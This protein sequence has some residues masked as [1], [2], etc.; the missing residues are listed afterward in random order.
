MP[1][2]CWLLHIL[3]TAL[4]DKQ[5]GAASKRRQPLPTTLP[6]TLTPSA[7]VACVCPQRIDQRQDYASFGTTIS[8]ECMY[9][10]ATWYPLVCPCVQ[11]S[12]TRRPG[13][14]RSHARRPGVAVPARLLRLAPAA[15]A[16]TARKELCCSAMPLR[17][18]SHRCTKAPWERGCQQTRMV[19]TGIVPA[20]HASCCKSNQVESSQCILLQVIL[21]V[22]RYQLGTVERRLPRRRSLAAY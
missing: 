13:V 12:R 2:S 16:A 15:L 11:S 21:P 6:T 18:P 4:T 5:L 17:A 19:S 8:C 22:G 20:L 7:Y 1:G 9:A 3:Q 14:Q 10:K